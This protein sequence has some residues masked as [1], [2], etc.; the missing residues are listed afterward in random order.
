MFRIHIELS[1][2]EAKTLKM[3]ANAGK[4]EQRIALRARVILYAAEGFTLKEIEEKTGLGWQSC[5]KWRKRFL[6]YGLDGLQDKPRGGRPRE[7][8]QEERL[9]VQALACMEP[10]D[11]SNRWTLSKLA[12]A[13]GLGKTTVHRILNEG[14]IKPHKVTLVRQKP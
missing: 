6:I 9:E 13:T 11:G 3:W 14:D 4:T 7:I 5:L 2:E 10:D 12:T 1:D 8:S